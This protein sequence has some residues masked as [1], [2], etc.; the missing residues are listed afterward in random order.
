VV[1][2]DLKELVKLR[3]TAA[4][5]LGF[6]DFHAMQLALAEQDQKE[7]LRLFD[8]LDELTRPAYRSAKAEIDA[9]L[10]RNCGV[11]VA[12]LRPWHY[13]DPFCQE[14]PAVFGEDAHGVYAGLD[15]LQVCQKFFGGIG[16]PVDDI[17]ARSDLYERPGKNP[18]AF[19]IDIDREG[20]VR[21]MANVVPG[22]EWLS[23][24]IHE[25]GHGVYSSKNIPSSV[26][27]VLRTDSHA[28]TTEGIAMMFERFV[29]SAAWLE[30]MGA[31]VPNPSEFDAAA[32]KV[33][34]NRLL[35]F[36]R[37]S[38]V[39]FRFEKALYAN[40][41]QD[42]NKLWWDLVEK[43]QEV[44]RPEERNEPD[45]AAKIHIVTVPC[46]Y[47]NYLL[48][49]LFA[50]QVHAAIC[51]EV[52]GGVVPATA[53]YAGNKQVGAFL[54]QRVFAPG[55][56]LPWNALTRHATGA[57]LSPLAFAAEITA[58]PGSDNVPPPKKTTKEK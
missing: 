30:A 24:M 48:G 51:R 32:A 22:R 2:P 35:I 3:N 58:A 42:L 34:R 7:V 38:Q 27:Y 57:D 49:E 18:H 1:L 46:Y 4:R 50:A 5:K 43:Y 10:A 37:W 21:V 31:K 54:R 55:R 20:D 11:S 8:E 15:I 33:R 39:M 29:E 53:M 17:L 44:Q 19:C 23:T 28:L 6:P 26:P 45:F 9:V 52:L 25:L 16:L 40:P 14:S 41:D 36:S 56:A 13:H 47:H 12:E